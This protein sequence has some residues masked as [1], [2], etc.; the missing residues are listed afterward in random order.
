MGSRQRRLSKV[1]VI[2]LLRV[3]LN[4]QPFFIFTPA[5]VLNPGRGGSGEMGEPR[6][7]RREPGRQEGGTTDLG[8]CERA[9]E[10]RS[11][12]PT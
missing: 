11:R 9:R 8:R 4:I 1:H 10:G 3:G 12:P 7:M 2:V 5:R 6:N